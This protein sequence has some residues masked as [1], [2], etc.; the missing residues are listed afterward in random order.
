MDVDLRPN[1]DIP[2]FDIPILDMTEDELVAA[3][4]GL[5]ALD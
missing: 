3:G 1:L 4:M 2:N 5:W